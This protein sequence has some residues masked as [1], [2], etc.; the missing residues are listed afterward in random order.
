M[1]NRRQ[2]T[3][4]A[5]GPVLSLALALFVLGQAGPATAEVALQGFTGQPQPITTAS[6]I[7]RFSS[8]ENYYEQYNFEA[9]LEGGREFYL[10]LRIANL[11]PGDGRLEVTTRVGHPTSGARL[12]GSAKLKRSEWSYERQSFEIRAGQTRVAGTPEEVQVQGAGSGFRYDLRFFR[13]VTGWQPGSGRIGLPGEGYYL[14][15]I[16]FPLA[17]VEGTIVTGEET[18]QVKG[19]GFALHSASDVPPYRIARRWVQFDARDGDTSIYLRHFV[20]AAG[21]APQPVSFLLVTR[22]ERVVFQSYGVALGAEETSVDAKTAARYVVPRRIRIEARAPG[23]VLR[24]TLDATEL[25]RRSA[26]L[27]ESGVMERLVI[28]QVAEPV[29]YNF[30]CGYHF[31]LESEGAGPL[32]LTGKATYSVNYLNR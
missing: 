21:W 15:Q 27:E 32:S 4:A 19:T 22:G 30:R 20:P 14:T 28:R 29:D 7:P 16:L 25:Y 24:G 26:M 23:Q 1:V 10:R 17:R 2:P 31:T 6:L 12:R 9:T 8:A 18:H 13:L 11:G 3:I 5:G